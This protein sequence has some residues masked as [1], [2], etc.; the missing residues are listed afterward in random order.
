M[1]SSFKKGATVLYETPR[2]AKA[3]TGKIRSVIETARGAWYEVVDGN[4]RA[5]VKLRAANLQ[6]AA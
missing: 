5:V 2:G 6:L 3:G 1:A 4:T